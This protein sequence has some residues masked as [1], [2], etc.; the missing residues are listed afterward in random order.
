[1]VKGK[2]QNLC[3]MFFRIKEYAAEDADVTYQLK[4]NFSQILDKL[5][6]KSY[7]MKSKFR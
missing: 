7:L 3:A 6:N 1:V 4:Q 2:N 5:E